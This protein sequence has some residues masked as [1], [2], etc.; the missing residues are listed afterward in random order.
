M[1][2]KEDK[3]YHKKDDGIEE[4]TG[5]IAREDIEQ[6]ISDVES[7][8]YNGDEGGKTSISDEKLDPS[9]VRSGVDDSPEDSPLAEL[10]RLKMEA[11]ENN[12]KY[13]RTMAELE[14]FKKRIKKEQAELY[15]YANEDIIKGLLPVV[16]NLERALSH[17]E[18]GSNSDALIEGIGMVLKQ[19]IEVLD[20]FGVKP[21]DSLGESFDPNYHEA[22]MRVETEDTTPNTVVN[23]ISKGYL[24]HDRLIRPSVVGVSVSKPKASTEVELESEEEKSGQ[25]RNIDDGDQ[26]EEE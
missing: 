11:K 1:G 17:G 20:R 10:E 12:D 5:E 13:L 7:K 16:D 14:N 15:K 25:N 4:S 21:I 9:E 23:E 3:S 22:M 26:K 24:L 2:K 8:I 6:A 19:F 18:D